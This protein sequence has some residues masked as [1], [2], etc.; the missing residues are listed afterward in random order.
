M[1]RFFCSSFELFFKDLLL[2]LIEKKFH[3]SRFCLGWDAEVVF[4]LVT[5]FLCL[6]SCH[7]QI[8]SHQWL[9]CSETISTWKE[10]RTKKI[11]VHNCFPNFST[12]LNN[13]LNLSGCTSSYLVL[14]VQFWQGIQKPLHSRY[15]WWN[16]SY[17]KNPSKMK[18][19]HPITTV[20]LW[21]MLGLTIFL[22][23]TRVYGNM[24]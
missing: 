7:K 16:I 2:I 14:T 19:C 1:I 20:S 10:P 13:I 9:S 4:N 5:I 18:G 23:S 8:Y 22:Y 17:S 6:H 15:V 12:L 11:F 24:A 3:L 21:E